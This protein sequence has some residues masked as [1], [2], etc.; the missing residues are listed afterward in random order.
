MKKRVLLLCL[1]ISAGSALLAQN[2]TMGV[3][4]AVPN[5]NAVLHVESPTANQ[6]FI[7]PRLTTAQRTAAPFL[8]SLGAADNGLLVYDTDEKGV[9]IWDGTKWTTGAQLQYPYA[10]TILS[11]TNNDNLFRIYYAGSGTENVGVAHFENINPNNGFSALFA[12]TNSITNGAVDLV[13]NNAANTNDAIGVTTNGLG[14]AGRFAV[15]NGANNSAAIYATT[16]GT[17]GGSPANSAAILGETATAFSAITGR[18]TAGASNGVTG[19]SVSSD[20]GSYAVLGSNSGAGP[21]GMFTVSNASNTTTAVEVSTAGTGGAARFKVMNT[22]GTQPAIWAETNSNAALSTPIYGLNTGTGDAAG[23]FRINNATSNQPGLFVETNG[24]GR[25][26]FI[27][28]TSTS[29][30][31]PGLY[32]TSASGHGIWSDHN[33]LTGYAAII[34]NI[35]TAN[36]NAAAMVESVGTGPSLW[37]IKSTDAV[38]GDAFM[39]ENLM[40]A[41]KVA[42]FNITDV[43]NT[44]NAVEVATMG[45]GNALAVLN[46]GVKVSTFTLSG[47][48]SIT[49]RVA[50]YLISSGGPY[51][52]SGITPA[53]TEGEIFYFYNSTVS[54]VTVEG[55]SIPASTGKTLIYLGGAFRGI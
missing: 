4:V 39:A 33:G 28:R 24:N 26:A 42:T 18:A 46:G 38:G 44:S 16:T 7:L 41:G 37:A 50:A 34:Q 47:G 52:F 49:T 15:N 45:N 10:D 9:F 1:L 54:A 5:P 48:T 23:V 35:N 20:P 53:I 43:A 27:R 8:T 31:Q 3:G 6:G 55:V 21:A 22:A 51:S 2:K 19:I 30:S 29:G 12:R 32:V 11:G 36:S 25:G 17:P 13:V 14:T 40:P